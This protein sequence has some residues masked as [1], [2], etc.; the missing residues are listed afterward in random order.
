MRLENEESKNTFVYALRGWKKAVKGEKNLKIDC[1]IAVIVIILG[2]L[3]KI[4]TGEWIICILLIGL[5]LSAELM[6]T[7]I[8][9]VVDM[10]TRKRNVL[11]EKAKD[12]A[13]GSVL[14]IAVT[15]AII[16]LIIFIPKIITF[17]SILNI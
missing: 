13:A 17:K 11:A 3:L 8:E 16:G 14:I 10:Y 12:I 9:T 2:I 4:N 5:V 6:N 1:A 7:A 15:A